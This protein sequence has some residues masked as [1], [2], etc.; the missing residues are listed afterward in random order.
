MAFTSC[1]INKHLTLPAPLGNLC[2]AGLGQRLPHR[3]DTSEQCWCAVGTLGAH[4]CFDYLPSQNSY[5][6][7]AEDML[8]QP[9]TCTYPTSAPVPCHHLYVP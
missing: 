7:E 3:T 6:S 9:C 5:C 8:T 4:L 1:V 2:M